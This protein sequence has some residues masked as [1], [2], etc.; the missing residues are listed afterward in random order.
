MALAGQCPPPL[1]STI[2]V[3]SS[4]GL[5]A[6]HQYFSVP[7]ERNIGHVVSWS[8]VAE[9]S[10]VRTLT[11]IKVNFILQCAWEWRQSC[12]FGADIRPEA[13]PT[14]MATIVMMTTW[15]MALKPGARSRCVEF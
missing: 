7:T 14:A 3:I 5:Q 13:I 8:E 4:Q 10:G 6:K 1:H 2:N 9:E 11:C 12:A 15:G